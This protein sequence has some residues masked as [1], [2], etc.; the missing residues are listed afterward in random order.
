V[1]SEGGEGG[2]GREVKE[3]DS[4]VLL[5]DFNFLTPVT[6]A[7]VENREKRKPKGSMS[8]SLTRSEVGGLGMRGRVTREGTKKRANHLARR[9]APGLK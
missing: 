9:P 4:S 8:A 3:A 5:P 6:S 2:G 7:A 1:E